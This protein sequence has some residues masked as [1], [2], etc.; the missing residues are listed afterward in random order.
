MKYF[1]IA[2]ERSGDLH[3]SNLIKELKDRDPEL[4]VVCWGGEQMEAA[5]AKL[6]QHYRI[7]SFMGFLEAIMRLQ[8][9]FKCIKLVKQLI[10]QENPDV[11]VFVDYAGFNLRI[12]PWAKK[13]GFKTYYY[14]SPKIWAWNR[15]RAYKIKKYIDRMFCILPFEEE[16]Y[17]RYDFDVNYVGNPVLDAIRSFTPNPNFLEK[18]ELKKEDTIIAILPGSRKG[19]VTKMLHYMLALLP[20]FPDHQ[21]VVAGVSNLSRDFYE[22]FLERTNVK[23]VYDETYDLLQHASVAIVTSGT[24]TL[25]TALFKV[26]QVVCYRTSSLS[27]MIGRM[28]VKVKYIS[29]PNLILNR[30]LLK[31]LIQDDFHPQSIRKELMKILENPEPIKS[32]YEELSALLGDR[33]ASAETAKLMLD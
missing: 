32:G 19:E 1:L 3:A 22:N 30:P 18:H 8:R 27:Y 29:L 12:A 9:V 2:G 14:I 13:K 28:V 33:N 5:G 31:E 7:L 16:F 26:P 15:S 4:E 25:E 20:A 23:I 10:T 11:I 6:L 17:K 21:F 24:A